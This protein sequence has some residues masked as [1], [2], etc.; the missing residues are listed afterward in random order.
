[1]HNVGCT[2]RG[3]TKEEDFDLQW[4]VLSELNSDLVDIYCTPTNNT[5]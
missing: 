2:Q 5:A 1:M 4:L 3:S